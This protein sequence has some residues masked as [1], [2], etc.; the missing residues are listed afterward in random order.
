M[1]LSAMV[2][3][4]A[5]RFFLAGVVEVAEP[6]QSNTSWKP[7]VWSCDAEGNVAWMLGEDLKCGTDIGLAL[8]REGG[9][10]LAWSNDRSRGKRDDVVRIDPADGRIVGSFGATEP[11]RRRSPDV[12]LGDVETLDV[13]ADGNVL[14]L[15]GGELLRVSPD[16]RPLPVWP[17]PPLA[18]DIA[19]FGMLGRARRPL[20]KPEVLDDYPRFLREGIG[21]QL[22]IGWDDHLYVVTSCNTFELLHR[23]DPR[24]RIVYSIELPDG[25]DAR[26]PP[27]ADRRGNVVLAHRTTVLRVDSDG[28]EFETLEHRSGSSPGIEGVAVAPDGEITL[29][30]ASDG[31]RLVP[32]ASNQ[33]DSREPTTPL[34][35]RRRIAWAVLATLLALTVARVA[36]L[37]FSTMPALERTVR[38]GGT[39]E[40]YPTTTG[41][42]RIIDAET[43]AQ[44][45]DVIAWILTFEGIATALLMLALVVATRHPRQAMLQALPAVLLTQPIALVLI[46]VLG[47]EI[48]A[49]YNF[50]RTTLTLAFLPPFVWAAGFI[51]SGRGPI[52]SG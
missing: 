34:P 14:A 16:G 40:G 26:W 10:L 7:R 3:D 32:V 1:E 9:S 38:T 12:A 8:G 39:L 20:G 5:G 43:A 25:F 22:G 52:D 29:A 33:N 31:G 30:V 23:I 51:V 13:D 18:W 41:R 37:M 45:L 11:A 15:I 17:R 6:S 28:A 27:R 4:D 44:W 49:I 50:Y 21:S 47:L 2:C 46:P 36:A 48:F 42:A 24:G 35:D 19:T